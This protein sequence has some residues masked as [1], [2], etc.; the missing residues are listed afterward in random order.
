MGVD[1]WH[2]RVM[3]HWLDAAV[4]PLLASLYGAVGYAGVAVAMAI[5][6]AMI[7]IPSELIL[8]FAGFLVATPTAL[9]PLTGAAWNPLLAI[10]AGTIGNTAGSLVAYT[11]GARG[12]RPLLE[13]YGRYLLIRAEELERA[14][15][16]F[17]RHG[18]ATAFWS[19]L[20]P[21]V[22]T[23]ISF[24]AGIAQ[25]PLRR[26]VAYSTLGAAIWSTL[27]VG[28]GALLGAQWETLRASLA[29][30]DTLLVV[31]VVVALIMAVA[32]RLGLLARFTK[33]R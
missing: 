12:G 27:L 5:E 33:R 3:L 24:P 23:F 11:L 9:E 20:L 6:S 16:F 7:P 14:E 1:L 17:A 8:P 2:D 13:R 29:P 30:V 4:I 18:D 26:F 28:A 25:M 10:L 15:S 21:V 22:R 32:W 31:I 19:R